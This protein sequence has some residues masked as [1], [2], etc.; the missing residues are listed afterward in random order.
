MLAQFDQ[1]HAFF[2]PEGAKFFSYPVRFK[3]VRDGFVDQRSPLFPAGK[4]IKGFLS[5]GQTISAVA[6]FFIT[7]Q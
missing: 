6:M 2:E 3:S 4:E 7:R 1:S 5:V